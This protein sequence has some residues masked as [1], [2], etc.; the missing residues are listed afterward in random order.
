LNT[1]VGILKLG[2]PRPPTSNMPLATTVAGHVLDKSALYWVV[3]LHLKRGERAF[4][5]DA[6]TFIFQMKLDSPLRVLD[7]L[8]S[9][10]GRCRSPCPLETSDQ[11]ENA[12]ETDYRPRHNVVDVC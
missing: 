9:C 10:C 11:L 8:F 6:T 1:S 7:T 2:S 3:K 12:Y 4:A 5:K